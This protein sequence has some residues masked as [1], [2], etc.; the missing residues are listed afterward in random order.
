MRGSPLWHFPT[1]PVPSG[2]VNDFKYECHL[3]H[4][5]RPKLRMKES[6]RVVP[7]FPESPL[8]VRVRIDWSETIGFLLPKPDPQKVKNFPQPVF[9]GILIFPK[10]GIN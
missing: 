4:L 7:L 8:D 3:H 5:D 9:L 2:M 6:S 1:T 10:K